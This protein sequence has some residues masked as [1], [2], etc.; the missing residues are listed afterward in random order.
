MA[1]EPIRCGS[2]SAFPIGCWAALI[3]LVICVCS[4]FVCF[5]FSVF[6]APSTVSCIRCKSAQT[7]A[8]AATRCSRM[9]ERLLVT[10]VC[11]LLSLFAV[12]LSCLSRETSVTGSRGGCNANCDGRRAELNKPRKTKVVAQAGRPP[13]GEGRKKKENIRHCGRCFRG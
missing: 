2:R 1:R 9:P 10:T 7:W 11:R 5:R 13:A 4:F 8:E 6:V 12:C 3:P